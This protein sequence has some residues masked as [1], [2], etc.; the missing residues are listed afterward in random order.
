VDQTV[1]GNN[2]VAGDFLAL[3]AEICAAV[4]FETVHLDE[5]VWI[6]KRFDPLPGGHFAAVMLFLDPF[7][8]TAPGGLSVFFIQRHE[9]LVGIHIFSSSPVIKTFGNLGPMFAAEDRDS[10]NS[11]VPGQTAK[12]IFLSAG[13]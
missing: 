1:T 8:T 6:E 7:I 3:Q 5:T 11:A 10:A 4:G 9:K 2:A 13:G 12:F